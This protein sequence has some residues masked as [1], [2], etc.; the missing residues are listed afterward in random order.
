MRYVR[1]VP[2]DDP[3][4]LEAETAHV[5]AYL[6]A[7]ADAD[8]DPQT[9][10]DDVDVWTE[11]HPDDPGLLRIVGESD[12]EPD[13]P[14]LRPGFDPLAGV[15]PALYEAEVAAALRDEEVLRGQA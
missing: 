10:A 7:R 4:A 14:Y 6:A 3:A 1:D 11:R 8:D 12:A 5:V 9:H 13:A 15:D 2:R